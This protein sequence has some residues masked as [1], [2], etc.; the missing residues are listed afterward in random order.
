MPGAIVLE[1]LT[2]S[3]AA[4]H[5]GVSEQSIRSW[6]KSGLLPV[7][8]TPLGLLVDRDDLDAF[9]AA[10]ERQR[11]DRVRTRQIGGRAPE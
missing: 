3:A 1:R 2:T 7:E 10:R 4:R 8:V 11:R 9:V 5:A 6:A